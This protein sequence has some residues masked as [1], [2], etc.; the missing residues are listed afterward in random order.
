[1]GGYRLGPLHGCFKSTWFP[2]LLEHLSPGMSRASSCRLYL[3]SNMANCAVCTQRWSLTMK[4][5]YTGGNNQHTRILCQMN[6]RSPMQ[7]RKAHSFLQG[8]KGSVNRSHAT[9][10]CPVV[11]YGFG[12]LVNSLRADFNIT[13][14]DFLCNSSKKAVQGIQAETLHFLDH[15]N[16]LCIMCIQLCCIHV[17][18]SD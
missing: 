16:F 9:E 15:I 17:S 6:G 18:S 14:Q 8:K 11:V 5:R 12:Q 7:V 3:T 1:M 2:L 13:C 10:L 4:N